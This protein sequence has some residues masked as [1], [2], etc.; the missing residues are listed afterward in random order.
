MATCSAGLP[1]AESPDAALEALAILQVGGRRRII[2][3]IDSGNTAKSSRNELRT[4]CRG[5]AVS[6]APASA[7]Q[8]PDDFRKQESKFVGSRILRIDKCKGGQVVEDDILKNLIARQEVSVR[9]A[10]RTIV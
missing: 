9:S 3:N 7:I 5:T 6:M 2:V 1:D 10:L 4:T 8:F